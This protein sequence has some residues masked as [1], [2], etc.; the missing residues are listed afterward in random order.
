M[1]GRTGRYK[2]R[3]ILNAIKLQLEG[4]PAFKQV[5]ANET[6]SEAIPEMALIQVYFE[7]KAFQNTQTDRNTFGGRKATLEP[8]IRI[9][10]ITIN[11]DVY[12]RQRSNIGTDMAA[13]VDAVD[14]VD[15]ILEAQIHKPFF[16]LEQL[17]AFTYSCERVVFEYATVKYAGVRFVLD[18]TVM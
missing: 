8:P 4:A 6:I 3:E 12:A 10:K 5:Q 14:E 2:I 15:E 11:V 7:R 18:I 9:N 1:T 17:Q 16:G 13:V